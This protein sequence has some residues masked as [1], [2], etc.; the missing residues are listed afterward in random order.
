MMYIFGLQTRESYDRVALAVVTW[1]LAF[2]PQPFTVSSEV[3]RSKRNAICSQKRA[4]Q[5]RRPEDRRRAVVYARAR[6]HRSIF[7]RSRAGVQPRS[8][9][10]ARQRRACIV[11][12][13]TGTAHYHPTNSSRAFTRHARNAITAGAGQRTPRKRSSVVRVSRARRRH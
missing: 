10:A 4:P 8:M 12:V 6:A 5:S 9:Q 13:S 1:T 2:L 11:V 7:A 3:N